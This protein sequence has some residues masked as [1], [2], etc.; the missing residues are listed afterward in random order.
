MRF[1]AIVA[2]RTG[3]ARLPGKALL[4]LMGLPVIS[5]LLRR[6]RTSRMLDELIF[7][8]T[9]LPQDDRLAQTV[10]AEGVRVFRGAVDDVLDRCVQ[11]G[12][13]LGV[14][15][16]VCITGDCPFVDGPSLD[17]VLSASR[18]LA[19]FDLLTTKPA[20]PHGI[21]YE[22]YAASV[23][24][25]VNR[26]ALGRPQR[27]HILNHLYEHE[28]RYRIVRLSPPPELMTA[29]P[30]FLLDTPEDYQRLQAMTAGSDDIHMTPAEL[31]RRQRP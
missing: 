11:A 8:T 28:E 12:A 9:T 31:I 5:L 1:G 13:L 20:F 26:Q 16:G 25:D 10:A 4:P 27:E 23:L 6:I 7:A 29:Q 3:S 21:D 24:A 18:T 2:A 22:V 30:L 17:F 14:E 15:Y 19:P